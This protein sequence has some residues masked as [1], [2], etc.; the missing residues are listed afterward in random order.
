MIPSGKSR[1]RKPFR[2]RNFRERRTPPSSPPSSAIIIFAKAPVAGQVKTRLCP[3]LTPDE[4]AS[5]HGSLVLDILERCQSLKGFDRILA[6]TPSIHHPFFR[7]M[8]ARFKL[9]VWDQ[10]GH[11]LGA[12][13]AGAFQKAF[14][15][16]YRSVMVI[17]TDIP[18]IDQ[19]LLISAEKSLQD[20]EV[21]MGP[22]V[23]GGYYLLGMRSPSPGLFDNM[24]WSTDRIF[25][26]T[27]QKVQA[28]GL[29]LALLP[30]LRDLDTV[31]DL[32]IFIQDAKNRQNQTFSSRTK[33]VLHELSSRLTG[34]E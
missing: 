23:D 28:M 13:M 33:N 10:T 34:R 2:S 17:G 31:E 27:K 26:L 14:E 9:P 15:M 19:S 18:G 16:P 29:S 30:E 22:T 21:V 3:P 8:E 32:Q 7:A 6:G 24:P 5:L 1:G 12:R 25:T 20:H 4:A 11:D